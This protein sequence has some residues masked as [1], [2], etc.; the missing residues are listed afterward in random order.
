MIVEVEFA[1]EEDTHEFIPPEWFGKDVTFDK[2][3]ANKNMIHIN[4]LGEMNL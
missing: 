1:S 4:D 3:Y 2:R